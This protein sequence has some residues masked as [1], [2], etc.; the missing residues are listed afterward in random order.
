MMIGNKA[1]Q[2][3][4]SSQFSGFGLSEEFQLNTGCKDNNENLLVFINNPRSTAI[5][6]YT[7]DKSFF[8]SFFY[9]FFFSK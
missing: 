5:S 3:Q 2:Q 7:K 4:N 9:F 6:S 1:K 8:F